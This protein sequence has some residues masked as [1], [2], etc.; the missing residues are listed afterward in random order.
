MTTRRRSTGLALAVPLTI[1]L[2]ACASGAPDT[3]TVVVQE[4]SSDHVDESLGDDASVTT[5]PGVDT[6]GAGEASG[7]VD[8]FSD[9]RPAVVQIIAEGTLRDPEVGVTATAGSGSGFLISPD[10]LAVTKIGRAH[11]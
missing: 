2:T 11:V 4:L 5:G 6:V 8:S 1:A 3:S 9:A 10:G 7:A